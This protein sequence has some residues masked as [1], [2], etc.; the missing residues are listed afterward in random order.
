MREGGGPADGAIGSNR[1]CS[2]CWTKVPAWS[3]RYLS[4]MS[5]LVQPIEPGERVDPESGNAVRLDHEVDRREVRTQKR[6]ITGLFVGYLVVG[7][8]LT[9]LRGGSFLT[10]EKFGILLLGGALVLGQGKAFIRD[11]APFLLLLFGYELMRGIADNMADI[12]SL[13][14]EDH[15][16]VLVQP[17]IDAEKLLFF[18]ELPTLWLQDKLF[19]EGTTHWYD[20]VAALTY[21]FHFVLPLAFGF[22]LWARDRPLFRRFT[23]TLLAMSYAAFVLFMLFPA[24]PPWLAAQWGYMEGVERPSYQAYKLFLPQ[25]F[26]DVDTFRLWTQASPNP[27][28]ALP[29]LHAAFPWLVL[30]FAVQTF[31][32]WGYL[33][34]IYNVALWFSVVY[35]SQHWFVDV[36][37]GM[38]LA[39]VAWWGMGWFFDRASGRR[40]GVRRPRSERR[41]EDVPMPSVWSVAAR[42]EDGSRL[43]SRGERQA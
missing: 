42:D 1:I 36:L 38:A 21:M 43:A 41:G 2:S 14:R 4:M 37:A 32:R 26:A 27:V 33:T 22:L 15:G 35:L 13:S 3:A 5:T 28:A 23:L 34:L 24:A 39:T 16:R 30:L 29:S 9:Y 11:W 31:G 25:R 10:P 12:G 7:G 17:L 40:N 18:G 20:A 8:G 6:L 19:V